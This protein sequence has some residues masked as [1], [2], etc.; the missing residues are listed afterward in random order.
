MSGKLAQ[1]FDLAVD[2]SRL[3]VASL[4]FRLDMNPD[5]V[6]RM[7]AHC[8]KPHPKYRIFQNKSVGAA[9]IDLKS[10]AAPGDY[11]DRIKGRN[12]GEHHARKARKRGYTVTIID[13]NDHIDALHEIN[14]SLDERQGRQMDDA[15]RQKQT[16][17]SPEKNYQY[18]G[19]FNSDGKLMAYSN[20][21][22]YGNFVAFDRLMGMR[23]N[24]GMM[25]LMLTE[26]VCRMIEHQRYGY[27]MY[28]TYFGASPGLQTFKKM[29]G[30]KPYR[31]KYSIQ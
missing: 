17:Y 25:H 14:T 9:L 15:Y 12:W 10:F 26:I 8:T 7:H 21:G 28:D 29:L 3:P 20:L 1:L 30:F 4:E 24:D 22:V 27:L 5:D 19:V 18:F 31:V 2:I 11:M 13:R 16:R 6:R 23:N